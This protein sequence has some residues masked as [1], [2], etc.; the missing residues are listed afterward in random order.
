MPAGGR[1]ALV[2]CTIDLPRR[3]ERRWRAVK[4]FCEEVFAFKESDERAR[5]LDPLASEV[6]R[7]ERPRLVLRDRLV[8]HY[9]V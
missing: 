3:D 4:N 8:S 2:H 9:S 5:E 7:R 1:V 6:R